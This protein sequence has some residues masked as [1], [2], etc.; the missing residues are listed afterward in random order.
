MGD[1]N[2][3]SIIMLL[4]INIREKSIG[5]KILYDTLTFNINEGEKVGI[6]GRNGAGKTTLFKLISGE[7][8]DF[9]GE[10]NKKNNITIVITQQEY[11]QE[12]QIT[13]LDYVL[14]HVPDF[15]K[16]KNIIDTYPDIMGDNIDM[17]AKYTDAITIFSERGYYSIEEKIIDSMSH[18][19]IDFERALMPLIK[20]SGGEK[21]FVE[22]VK[23][24]Y[25]D[26]DIA[27]IDEPTN[28][29]DDLGKADFIEWFKSTKHGILVITHDRDVLTCVDRIIEIKDK[30]AFSFPGN[31]DS[32]LKQN[33]LISITN[34]KSYEESVKEISYLKKQMENIKKRGAHASTRV[35]YE[36]VEKK[37]DKI[38]S[39]LEKPSIWIDE[40]SIEKINSKVVDKYD[41]YKD[42]NIS[43]I[44]RNI[45]EHK[46]VLLKVTDLSI[47]Y[48]YP[49]FSNINF[50]LSHGDRLRLKG[51]NG[52]GKTSLIKTILAK[53][54]DKKT[55][56]K[57]YS[58]VITTSTKIKLGIYEQE[59]DSKY[60]DMPL[61][62]AITYIYHEKKVQM[63]NINKILKDY[64]FNPDND[65]DLL[66]EKLSGGQKARFQIIKMLLDNPNLLILDEPT[67]HLDLPSIEELENSL[68]DFHGAILY[69]SHDSYFVK[70]L[71]GSTIEIG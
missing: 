23:I 17:I 53:I 47:G 5:A 27:L 45:K 35:M 44:S 41:K 29:M 8:T 66:I 67:N 65:K 2:K 25:S 46:N 18:Y 38:K 24:M 3:L 61:G 56:T 34:I 51:R 64:L 36:R 10:I 71:G 50:E 1:I 59:I 15:L 16:L 57:I 55:E 49:L 40:E 11:Q 33:S 37:Y 54:Y 58:G 32:Y 19:K 7:D 9:D 60:L 6:V 39:N 12:D 22:L 62:D 48:N 4:N 69:V 26:S 42:K 52:A 68:I 13:S 43:L 21:R 31:Y 63:P 14:Q 30:Q 28:H 20:L 70:K